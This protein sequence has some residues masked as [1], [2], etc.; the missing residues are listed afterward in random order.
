MGSIIY[1]EENKEGETEAYA[2]V[3]GCFLIRNPYKKANLPCDSILQTPYK[4]TRKWHYLVFVPYDKNYDPT[5]N[6][7]DFI[8][9]NYCKGLDGYHFVITKE[10]AT[11]IHWNLLINTSHNMEAFHMKATKHFK[12]FH[13]E[14]KI[15]EHV[16]VY[17][18]ITKDYYDD[19]VKDWIQY[20]DY[21]FRA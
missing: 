9:K 2:G 4:L 1:K 7:H 21:S 18:Y 19:P 12:I 10:S 6:A 14:V 3:G 20:I 11:K 17:H 15:N 5:Y 13:Q 16:N 8:R